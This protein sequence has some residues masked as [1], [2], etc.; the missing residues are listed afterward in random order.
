MEKYLLDS[1]QLKQVLEKTI[2][3]FLEYQYKHGC[4]EPLARTKAIQD[5]IESIRKTTGCQ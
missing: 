5:V 2:D 1:W 3:L 4:D